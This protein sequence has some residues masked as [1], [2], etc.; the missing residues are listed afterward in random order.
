MK[1]LILKSGEH[2]LLDDSDYKKL[3]GYTWRILKS[4]SRAYVVRSAGVAGKDNIYLHRSIIG[5][6]GKKHIIHIN[7]NPLDNRKE[8][9]Q[10]RNKKEGI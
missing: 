10:Y 4:N 6:T 2:V 9:L 1:E 8:N 5:E 3:A 7:D